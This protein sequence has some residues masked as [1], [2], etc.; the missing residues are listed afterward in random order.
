MELTPRQTA[1]FGALAV[2]PIGIYAAMSGQFTIATTAL[3]AINLSLIVGSL[4][5]IFG[6]ESGPGHGTAH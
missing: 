6:P 1:T 4:L 2:L 5:L 3:A